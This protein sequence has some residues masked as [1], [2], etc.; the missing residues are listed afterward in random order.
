MNHSTGH[1][2]VL[3]PAHMFSGHGACQPP[4]NITVASDGN[5]HHVD[6]LGKHE[7]RELQRRVLGVE[8]RDEFA[9]G[10]GQVEWG[11]VGLADH[12]R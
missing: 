6:V 8:A 11:P 4:K 5:R 7:H 9:L 3:A 2:P 12:G 1:Q 10:L